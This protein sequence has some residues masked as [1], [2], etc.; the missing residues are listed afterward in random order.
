MF[1]FGNPAYT[2]LVI[3]ASFG[4]IF[5]LGIVGAGMDFRLGAT[6]PCARAMV[7]LRAAVVLCHVFSLPHC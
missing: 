1:D 4:V 7:G 5:A 3:T 2:T 6:Q